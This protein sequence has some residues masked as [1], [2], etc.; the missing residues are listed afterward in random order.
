MI[1]SYFIYK[2]F[3]QITAQLFE[4]AQLLLH[5]HTFLLP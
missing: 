2:F 4:P 3:L 1:V 5:A